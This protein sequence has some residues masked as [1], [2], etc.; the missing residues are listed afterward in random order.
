MVRDVWRRPNPLHAPIARIYVAD[1]AVHLAD[2]RALCPA[3][4]RRHDNISPEEFDDALRVL[5]AQGVVVERD[6]GDGTALMIVEPKFAETCGT[7]ASR[8]SGLERWRGDYI[9]CPLSEALVAFGL[10]EC[11]DLTGINPRRERRVRYVANY[12]AHEPPTA[13][14]R[15]AVYDIGVGWSLQTTIGWFESED[16]EP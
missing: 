7:C 4:V 5:T 16:R 1:G 6:L 10:A 12:Y 15:D 14:Y 9:Q 13:V 3:G 2:G 8:R 11:G